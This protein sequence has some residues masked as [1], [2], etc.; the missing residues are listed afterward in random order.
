MSAISGVGQKSVILNYDDTVAEL[1]GDTTAMVAAMVLD[2][3]K[4]QRHSADDARVAEE[5]HIAAYEDKEV[6]EM[7]EQADHI[8]EGS[9]FKA[10]GDVADGTAKIIGT[11]DKNID[12]DAPVKIVH[13][14]GTIGAGQ[15]EAAKTDSEA[16]GK[17]AGDMAAASIR[18]LQDIKDLKSDAQDAVRSALEFLRNAQQTKATTDQAPINGIRG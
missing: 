16:R 13:A 10:A 18:R 11:F 8:R 4:N 3:A 7:H 1:G 12:L 14:V 17:A 5:Q 15:E 9:L 6:Q 2:N